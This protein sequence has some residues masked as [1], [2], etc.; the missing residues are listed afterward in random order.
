MATPR[1][2]L[3]GVEQRALSDRIDAAFR[4]AG[5]AGTRARSRRLT[6]AKA[7]RLVAAI[8]AC[9][10]TADISDSLRL[11]LDDARAAIDPYLND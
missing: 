9:A 1:R 8:A 11:A 5:V 4:S 2:E 6:K 7:E 3:T 10:D